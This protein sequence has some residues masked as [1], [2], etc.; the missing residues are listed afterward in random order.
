MGSNDAM[1]RL[2]RESRSAPTFPASAGSNVINNALREAAGLDVDDDQADDQPAPQLPTLGGSDYG[3]RHEEPPPGVDESEW[4]AWIY[5]KGRVLK[6]LDQ[7]GRLPGEDGYDRAS[8]GPAIP[9][10][11]DMAA[12]VK[13]RRQRWRNL[14]GL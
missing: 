11:Y 4:E 2:I 10:T 12:A 13:A 3:L 5:R 9:A 7:H 1:N 6:L 8:T 14:T